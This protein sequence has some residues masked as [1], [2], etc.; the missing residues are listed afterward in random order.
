[1]RKQGNPSYEKV[2]E[3]MNSN[4]KTLAAAHTF[5]SKKENLRH[6]FQEAT[7]KL[8]KEEQEKGQLIERRPEYK[9]ALEDAWAIFK[10]SMELTA[11]NCDL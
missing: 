9:K 4:L 7:G 10:E 8:S 1:M 5:K 6:T 2:H 3:E 11:T